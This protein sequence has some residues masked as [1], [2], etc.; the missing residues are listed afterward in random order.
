VRAADNTRLGELISVGRTSEVHRYGTDGAIKILK[1]S[2]PPH[3]AQVEASFTTSVRRLGVAAPEV[4]D[5]LHVDGRAAIHFEMIDGPSMLERMIDRP[6]DV[7]AL[8]CELADVQR[9]IH[10]AGVPDGLPGLV[11]RLRLK[12]GLATDLDD[13]E[14]CRAVDV[15][16]AMPRG[17]ALLHGDLHPGNVLLGASGPVVIDWFDAAVGHPAADI[18]RTQ[19]LLRASGATDLRHLP[20]ASTAVVSEVHDG[21]MARTL[22]GRS[23][24]EAAVLR[25][26]LDDW[27]RLRAAGR[28]AE[29]TDADV[30]GLVEIWRQGSAVDDRSELVEDRGAR[31]D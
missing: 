24:A 17:A 13:L 25:R 21:Y 31:G 12:L 14:R 22:A 2:T 4:R 30:S 7:A 1:R 8:A 6:A 11:D 27:L 16:E 26:Q 20:G 18:A 5:V 15:L 28:L 10:E 19:L 29:H 3:W 9:A 23:G